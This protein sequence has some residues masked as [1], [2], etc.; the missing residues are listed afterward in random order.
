MFCTQCGKQLE[1]QDRFCGQCGAAQYATAVPPAAR[2]LVRPRLRR[3]FRP[4]VR[5]LPALGARLRQRA[6]VA[7]HVVLWSAPA[8]ACLPSLPFKERNARRVQFIAGRS[9]F[10][11]GVP[12]R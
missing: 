9:G 11:A 6:G 4:V 7:G 3:G 12:M 8:H 1:A 10:R 2:R 5:G